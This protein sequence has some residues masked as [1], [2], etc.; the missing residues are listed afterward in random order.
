MFEE[1]LFTVYKILINIYRNFIFD[2]L[3]PGLFY[4]ISIKTNGL[5]KD[6][7][8]AHITTRTS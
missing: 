6:S 3:N 2:E 7:P 5:G 1:T 8:T 4:N